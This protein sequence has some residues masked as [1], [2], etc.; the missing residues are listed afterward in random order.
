MLIS[1]FHYAN[2]VPLYVGTYTKA[3]GSEGIYAFEMD[4]QSGEVKPLGLAATLKNPTFLA[5]HPNGRFLYS[6][7]ENGEGSVSALAIEP[8]GKLR[9]IN[10][11]SS[12]GN[13]PCHVS[14]DPAGSTVF[15]A[16]YGGGSVAALPIRLDGGLDAATGFV[17]HTG[18]SVNPDRQKAPHAH[19]IYPDPTG[20][21]AYA[22]DLGLDKVLTYQTAGSKLQPHT[23]AS[24]S[25]PAGSGPRHMAFS[26]DG[27]RA[28][29]INELLNTLTAFAHTPGEFKEIET[30][31]TL[32]AGFTGKS[33]TAEVA[34]HPGGTFIYGSNR[35]HDSI[36]VWKNVDGRLQSVEHV[37][38]GGKGPRHFTLDP[39]GRFLLVANQQ[40]D[41]VKVFKVD[42][43]TG[44][45]SAS[46]HE[47][48][49]GAPV[50]IV[51]APQ[52]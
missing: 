34:V 17:Q 19:G 8:G 43:E 13:G 7:A 14:V 15:V 1:S 20:K 49:C 24:A 41:N 37:L 26:P 2:G 47:F 46:G 11:Q 10:S 42:A 4:G 3:G 21:F 29:V 45:L 27:K 44:K 22:C 51:F 48:Q 38:T 12:R 50:C 25:V 33:S 16:N 36:A 32:P 28:Y 31:T 6:V 39:S 30:V 5:R 23:I 40:S 35:G 9:E 18:S 52:G